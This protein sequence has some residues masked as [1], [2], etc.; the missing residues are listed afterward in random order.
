MW[1]CCHFGGVFWSLLVWTHSFPHARS[2]SQYTP[3]MQRLKLSESSPSASLLLG[4][5]RFS[6]LR[7]L[8]LNRRLPVRQIKQESSTHTKSVLSDRRLGYDGQG[9]TSMRSPIWRYE[10]MNNPVVENALS[11]TRIVSTDCTASCTR[12]VVPSEVF[13]RIVLCFRH[14]TVVVEMRLLLRIM[15]LSA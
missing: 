6:I 15:R 7:E 8:A 4:F 5:P 3:I 10:L 11:T 13:K 9:P 1:R 12:K 2:A 14:L